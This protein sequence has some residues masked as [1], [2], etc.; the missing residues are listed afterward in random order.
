M[1]HTREAWAYAA[2]GRGAAFR[3][4]TAE[5]TEA[6]SDAEALEEPYWIAYFDAA[7]LAGVTGGR[8][9]ELARQDPRQYADAAADSI[10]HA[11]ATRGPEAGRSHALDLI[12]LAEC[13]FLQGDVTSAVDRTRAAADA[14]GRTQSN[15]VRTQ[16]GQL[17]P[18]TVR[19]NTSR[20][21]SEARTMI[22]DVLAG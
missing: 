13:H 4:A 20:A 10:R 12:G 5:A 15:R 7:E 16:L 6:L 21:M 11:L 19:R 17:Y 22:R 3:R 9:L 14:A 2:M 18:Y 8:L 1:L